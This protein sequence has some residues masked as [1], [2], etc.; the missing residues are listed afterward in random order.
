MWK[1]CAEM[2]ETT[3]KTKQSK[4]ESEQS[5]INHTLEPDL[6]KNLRSETSGIFQIKS[7]NVDRDWLKVQRLKNERNKL[8]ETYDLF[9]S[10]IL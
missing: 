6:K 10:R 7:E 1:F 8:K 9:F 5:K 4:F 2:F 3:A